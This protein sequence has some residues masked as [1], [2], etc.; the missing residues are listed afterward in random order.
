MS[1]DMMSM[2]NAC[3]FRYRYK[4]YVDETWIKGSSFPPSLGGATT[5][6]WAREQL[7]RGRV[8]TFRCLFFACV[9]Y[10]LSA[11]H[12]FLLNYRYLLING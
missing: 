7:M 11:S 1:D 4:Y 10:C 6:I 2:L 5:A 3:R 9:K 8:E 12:S